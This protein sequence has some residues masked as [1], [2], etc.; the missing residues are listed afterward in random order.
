VAL[1]TGG[2]L[3]IGAVGHDGDEYGFALPVGVVQGLVAGGQLLFPVGFVVVAT[4]LGSM[5]LGVGAEAGQ[6]GVPGRGADL[7]EFVADVWRAQAVSIG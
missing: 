1:L 7:A 3:P 4:L 6:A 5:G 2:V